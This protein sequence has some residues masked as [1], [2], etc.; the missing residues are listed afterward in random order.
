MNEWMNVQKIIDNRAYKIQ[1]MS[2]DK[3]CNIQ[4]LKVP[5]DTRF[6]DLLFIP[7]SCENPHMIH[8]PIKEI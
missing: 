8:Y 7:N 3:P 6:I 2:A 5:S 4:I 1:D